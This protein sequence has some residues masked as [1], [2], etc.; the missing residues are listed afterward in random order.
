MA[1]AYGLWQGLNQLKVIGAE[2]V[3]VFGDSRI[4]IQELNG[5]SRSKNERI[6]R[7]I[8][9]IRSKANTFRKIQFFHVLRNLNGLADSAANKS[10]AIG[11]NELN[12]NSVVSI[13]IPP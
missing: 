6:V 11:L 10:I 13:D 8:K 3:M 7:L 9:R 4:I 2:E 5:G 1:E 12:V